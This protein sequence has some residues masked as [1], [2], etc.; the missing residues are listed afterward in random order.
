M[1]ATKIHG[2]NGIFAFIPFWVT[3]AYIPPAIA[4]ISKEKNNNRK[5]PDN[6]K[7]IPS[8]IKITPSPTPIAPIDNRAYPSKTIPTIPPP[9]IDHID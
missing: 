6:P 9:T 2:I 4:A 1:Y 3:S 8:Q 7:K 5:F